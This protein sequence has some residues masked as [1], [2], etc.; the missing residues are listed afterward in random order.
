MRNNG[1]TTSG[2]EQQGKWWDGRRL[3]AALAAS[4]CVHAVFLWFAVPALFRSLRPAE[5]A[6]SAPVTVTLRDAPAP[7]K[8]V[9]AP[10]PP[11]KK[12]PPPPPAGPKQGRFAGV[13]R[14]STRRPGLPGA[15]GPRLRRTV[16]GTQTAS[17]PRPTPTRETGGSP[18]P[19]ATLTGSGGVKAPPKPIED[20]VYSGGGRGGK[21]LPVAEANAGGGKGTETP[22]S[23]PLAEK[24]LTSENPDAPTI[25]AAPTVVAQTPAR[26]APTAKGAGNRAE[27]QG[28]G[29]KDTPGVG[30]V[31]NPAAPSVPV[32]I[33][34]APAPLPPLAYRKRTLANGL[35]V[36]SAESHKTPTVAIYVWY[37]VGGKDDPEGRSGFAHL[38]EHMMF[39]ST[40]NMKSENLDRL[41]EDVG[42]EN[43][44]F[45]ADDVTV[46][47][48]TVPSN[49][50]ETLLWAEA[51]RM[52][53]LNIVDAAFKSERDVVKEEYRQSVL[54]PPY[55]KLQNAIVERSFTTHPYRRSVIGN[56]EQLNAATIDDVRAF[57]STFYRPDN[58]NLVVVGDF[59]PKQLDAWVD[60]YFAKVAKP[61]GAIPRVKVKEPA[62]KG[63]KRYDETGPNVPLP[64]VAMTF[65][66]PGMADKDAPALNLAN[67]IL[68]GGESSRLYQSLVYTQQIAQEANSYVDDRTDA[69][70]FVVQLVASSGKS[71]DDVEKAAL[72]ELE[73][74][75]K[76][77]VTETELTKAKNQA[78]AGVL[79]TRETAD[80][81]AQAL[82]DAATRLGDPERV[83]TDLA[84]LQAVTREDVQRALQK[85]LTPQNRVVI[86]YTQ[87][88]A[89]ATP[90]AATGGAK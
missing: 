53:N 81:T 17:I 72:A 62:R 70:L 74:V 45:T 64:S 31:E 42:G 28:V 13:R 5:V 75:K 21:T 83:N 50:L 77:G 10:T 25:A 15:T 34:A 67:V 66:I 29:F 87:A 37:K 69:G 4:L 20:V 71:L 30:T 8:P 18:A 51:E 47:H 68:S 41:T 27:T 79:R 7:P 16:R 88:A 86:R 3:G 14:D 85:Y 61:Q 35:T 76:D 84:A 58:A 80:G 59:E 2:G 9:V 26:I 36:L 39:K 48:E 49:Y 38:F 56:I 90:A 24:V 23:A 55:G 11:P 12:T 65:L 54:A 33:A 57:H 19:N 32:V 44:A 46:Y 6:E 63:E 89:T 52:A 43:N 60:K 22:A 82:G 78:I 73:R 1:M 40:K